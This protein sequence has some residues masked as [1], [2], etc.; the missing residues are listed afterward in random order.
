MCTYGLGAPS[1]KLVRFALL[2][3]A[4]YSHSSSSKTKPIATEFWGGQS[5]R[6]VRGGDSNGATVTD[7]R[8]THTVMPGAHRAMRRAYQHNVLRVARACKVSR[9]AKRCI[10]R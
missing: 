8:R 4:S 7:A 2:S 6:N 3:R 5:Q 9:R 1:S 10:Q